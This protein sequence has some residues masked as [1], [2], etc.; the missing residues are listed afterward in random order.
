MPTALKQCHKSL[1]K[2]L[3]ALCSYVLPPFVHMCVCMCVYASALMKIYHQWPKKQQQQQQQQ[4]QVVRVE[5][6]LGHRRSVIL[7]Y[8]VMY[9]AEYVGTIHTYIQTGEMLIC[10]F[11]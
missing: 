10:R 1:S 7:Y 3:S 6:K 11:I 9:I 5:G 8:A 4:W 2:H